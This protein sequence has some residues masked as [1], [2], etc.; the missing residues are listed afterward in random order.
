MRSFHLSE[1]EKSEIWLLTRQGT[2]VRAVSRRLRRSVASVRGYMELT[3]GP[4]GT[5][6]GPNRTNNAGRRGCPTLW[7]HRPLTGEPLPCW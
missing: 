4:P 6:K 1:D 3:M 5:T 2:S 7:Q